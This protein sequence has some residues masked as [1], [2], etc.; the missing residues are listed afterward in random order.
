MRSRS[1]SASSS[2][3]T[4]ATVKTASEASGA[5][6]PR[7]RSAGSIASGWTTVPPC[8][9]PRSSLYSAAKDFTCSVSASVQDM[10]SHSKPAEPWREVAIR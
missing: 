2:E 3:A 5:T 4:V 9:R 10:T 6:T 7:T 1:A 8:S